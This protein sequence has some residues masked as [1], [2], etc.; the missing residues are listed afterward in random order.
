MVSYFIVLFLPVPGLP[1]DLC[2][3]PGLATEKL[4]VGWGKLGGEAYSG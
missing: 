1:Y 4:H 3:Y 2:L